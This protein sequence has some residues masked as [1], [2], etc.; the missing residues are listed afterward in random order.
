MAIMGKRFTWFSANGFAMSRLDW[1]LVSHDL[2]KLWGG[3]LSV[4]GEEGHL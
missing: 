2:S 4:G 3:V 1:F